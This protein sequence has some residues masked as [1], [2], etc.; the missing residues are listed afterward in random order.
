M[1]KNCS[2]CFFKNNEYPL[3]YDFSEIF[4]EENENSKSNNYIYAIS[5]CKYKIINIIYFIFFYNSIS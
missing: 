2:K 4:S 3:P 5:D 1:R